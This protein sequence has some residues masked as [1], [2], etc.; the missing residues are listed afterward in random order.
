MATLI[1]DYDGTLHDSTHIYLPAFYK[2]HQQ[3]IADGLIAD[4]K[5]DETRVKSWIGLSPKQMWSDFMPHWTW[6]KAKPYSKEIGHQM[7]CA[8]KAGKA[9]WYPGVEEALETLKKGG[10]RLILLS[11]CSDAYMHAHRQVFPIDVYFESVYCSQNGNTSPKKEVL[12]K[13]FPKGIQ[14]LVM[15]GDRKTDIDAGRAMGALTIGCT[16]GFGKEKELEESHFSIDSPKECLC[17]FYH[18]F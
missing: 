18:E 17:I 6:Q 9:R 13:I 15:I 11:N 10:H 14:D 1:F 12:R 2:V 3:L 16:Y 4:T 5:I 7:V 8:I